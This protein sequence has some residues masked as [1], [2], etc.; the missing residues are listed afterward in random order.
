MK[1]LIPLA[2]AATVGTATIASAENSFSLAETQPRSTMV[3]FDIVNTDAPGVVNIYD[4]HGHAVGD[5]LGFKSLKAGVNSDLRIRINPP[6]SNDAL[7]V[8]MVN[9]TDVARQIVEFR[10]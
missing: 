3:H 1:A 7:A 9:G 2:V 10:D 8:L 6:A 5:L 4:Y